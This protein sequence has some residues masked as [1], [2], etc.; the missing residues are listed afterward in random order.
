MRAPCLAE[1][2]RELLAPASPQPDQARSYGNWTGSW[3]SLES[4]L[5]LREPCAY[6][7]A[8]TAKTRYIR[9]RTDGLHRLVPVMTRPPGSMRPEQLVRIQASAVFPPG[10]L[11]GTPGQTAPLQQTLPVRTT[12]RPHPPYSTAAPGRSGAIPGGTRRRGQGRRPLP[13]GQGQ[14]SRPSIPVCAQAS[15]GPDLLTGP[16]RRRASAE[17]PPATE[18]HRSSLQSAG[19]HK[20]MICART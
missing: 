7:A 16:R 11:A 9:D 8:T 12:S 4:H 19:R 14:R 10:Y 1:P 20:R 3:R 2:V 6:E 5:S 18:S 15:A 13:A 17:S